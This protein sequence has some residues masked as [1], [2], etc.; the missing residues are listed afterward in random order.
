MHEPIEDFFE[1][2]RRGYVRRDAA[3]LA[4]MFAY[5][6]HVAC[7]AG[8]VALVANL[9]KDIWRGQIAKLF[10]NYDSIGATDIRILRLDSR[11][12]SPRLWLAE[13]HW[14]LNDSQGKVLY[15]FHTLYVLAE[16]DGDLRIA[17]AIAPD[18]L[19]RHGE[20]MARLDG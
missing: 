18:E 12:L 10:E 2:Y 3:A 19:L 1:R 4:E 7:D 9:S 17:S 11:L 16:R 13:L 5:P 6:S 8:S 14:E 20:Y 15:D